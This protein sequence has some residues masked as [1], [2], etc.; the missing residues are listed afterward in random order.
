MNRVM[1]AT[2]MRGL[3]WRSLLLLLWVTVIILAVGVLP[4]HA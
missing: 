1:E 3:Y 4:H 2:L